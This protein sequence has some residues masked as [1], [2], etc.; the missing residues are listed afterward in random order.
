MIFCL[1]YL[2]AQ[3]SVSSSGSPISS[4]IL[5]SLPGFSLPS[6]G[7]GG[8]VP[9]HLPERRYRAFRLLSLYMASV[10]VTGW[11]L[12]FGIVG[13]PVPGLRSILFFRPLIKAKLKQGVT[14]VLDRYAFSGVAFTGAKEVSTVWHPVS[15]CRCV[16]ALVCFSSFAGSLP[17]SVC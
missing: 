16:W 13:K 8:G 7:E 10:I 12:R 3:V 5:C 17:Q 1:L 4:V 6:A 9:W 2:G 15:G 11:R 14:L